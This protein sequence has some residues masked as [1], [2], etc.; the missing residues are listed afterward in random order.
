MQNSQTR[1]SKRSTQGFTLIE[2]LTVIAIISILAGLTF[3]ALPRVLERARKASLNSALNQMRVG[4]V[5]YMSDNGTYPPGYGFR[6]GATR[7]MNWADVNDWFAKQVDASNGGL[8]PDDFDRLVYHLKPVDVYLN[9]HGSDDV[10]D[11][12]GQS[13]DTDNDGALGLMEFAPIGSKDVVSGALALPTV[14]YDGSNLRTEVQNQLSQDKRPIIYVPVNLRQFKAAKRY[15]L[16]RAAEIGTNADGTNAALE[17]AIWE[18]DD[19][20]LR[21]VVG[22]F[23]PPT[24]DA[25]VLIS[26]GPSAQTYGVLANSPVGSE[27]RLDVYHIAA[28]RTFFLATRDLNQDQLL[29]FDFEARTTKGAGSVEPYQV[30]TKKGSFVTDNDLPSKEMPRGQGPWI[31]V[32]GLN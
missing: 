6:S 4:L 21:S 5:T 30:S 20:R 25:F 3:G 9:L 11:T 22:N 13:Y 18:P 14:R 12:F 15:W 17:A 7:R 19:A 23:P 29:D 32:Y 10:L 31:Y 24:Y 2:L 27:G 26:V 28:L 1:D 16:E 8:G